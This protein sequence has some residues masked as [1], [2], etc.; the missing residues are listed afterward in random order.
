M[1]WK[2]SSIFVWRFCRLSSRRVCSRTSAQVTTRMSP[3][4]VAAATASFSS[5][6]IYVSGSHVLVLSGRRSRFSIQV[7]ESDSS[8]SLSKRSFFASTV[9]FLEFASG[10]FCFCPGRWIIEKRYGSFFSLSDSSLSFLIP[11][12]CR[13]LRTPSSS[14]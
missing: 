7:M 2:S 11:P 3:R 6:S 4:L 9:G 13:L 14:L 12:R 8:K 1:P 10:A 5:R